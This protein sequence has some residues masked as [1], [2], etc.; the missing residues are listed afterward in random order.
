MVSKKKR[1][2]KTKNLF[3]YIQKKLGHKNYSK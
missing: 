1:Q 2:N 3:R